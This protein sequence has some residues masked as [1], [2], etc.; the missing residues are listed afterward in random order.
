[1]KKIINEKLVT[2]AIFLTLSF[3]FLYISVRLIFFMFTDIPWYDRL[4]S[5][6][7]LTAELFGLVHSLGYFSTILTTIR[8]KSK[9]LSDMETPPLDSYPP[10]A[11][12]VPSYK[13][14]LEVLKDTLICL[15]NLSY[16]N[17]FLYL[18]DDSRY[19]KLWDTEENVK[20][21]RKDVEDMCE[22]IG[23]NLF[24][25]KWRG[26]KAGIINDF[27]KYKEG[28]EPENLQYK[29]FQKQ[30][31]SEAEKYIIVFDADMNPL[32][33]FV[34]TLVSH[35]EKEPQAAFIQTPQ[36][37]TNF[38]TNRVARAAGLQQIIFFEYIC[39]SK[40][41]KDAM[42]CCGS[43]V[44]LRRD[45]LGSVGGFDESSVTEDFATSLR[46]HLNGWKTLY[47]NKVCAFGMGPEDLGA[48]FKQQFRWA[49]GTLNLARN[50][51][52]MFIRQ[53]RKIPLQKW[54][55]YYLSGTHYM[56][57]WFFLIMVLFPAIFLLFNIPSYFLDPTMYVLVFLPYFVISLTTAFWT[58]LLRNYRPIYLLYSML[59][60]AVSFPVLIKAASY[61]ICGIK[62]SF[63]VTPKS[64]SSALPLTSLWPQLLLMSFC[65]FAAFW[66]LE[67]LF[68]EREPF[69]GL[70]VN[71][72]WCIMNGAIL[73][74]V[75]FFNNPEGGSW[76]EK[77]S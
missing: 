32:P 66:G 55:E 10:V 68:Y 63:T 74:S 59:I 19:D 36:Y 57:G 2:G 48:Y 49:L 13:E 56:I 46:L 52:N 70:A 4:L 35:M 69:F 25:R 42:F 5:G 34:E 53:Y 44:L 72:F 9:N 26:A 14:P 24:R 62:G 54:W 6:L 16:P 7:L 3:T 76:F 43:N 17:K 41:V 28:I 12:V 65:T 1:M 18:L 51:P 37:Y 47:Y 38:E 31:F 22:W 27:I 71:V 33:D 60:S 23:I 20:A 50:L 67:R 15:R 77:S 40:G 73:S 39:E 75:L 45:A 8:Q 58:L 11:I 29:D 21:Y 61:A 64:G 30:K